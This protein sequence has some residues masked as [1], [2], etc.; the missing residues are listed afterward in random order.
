MNQKNW[1]YMKT[2]IIFILPVIVQNYRNI[3]KREKY[4]RLWYYLK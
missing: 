1:N 4:I 3:K 2:E